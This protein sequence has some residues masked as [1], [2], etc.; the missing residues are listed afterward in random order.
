[1]R[2]LLIIYVYFSNRRTLANKLEIPIPICLV[3]LLLLTCKFFCRSCVDLNQPDIAEEFLY[4]PKS[5]GPAIQFYEA[6]SLED[7]LRARAGETEQN[8][9]ANFIYIRRGKDHQFEIHGIH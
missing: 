2:E 5:T 1:M 3:S 9:L 6:A 4:F 8:D 7:D